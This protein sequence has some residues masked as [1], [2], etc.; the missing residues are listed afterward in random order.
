[1]QIGMQI[2]T[3]YEPRG[4]SEFDKRFDV[5]YFVFSKA[6][7][8][9]RFYARYQVARAFRG[10]QL[11]GYTDTTEIGYA[12]LIKL[13]LHWSAFEQLKKAIRVQ[14]TRELI[15]LYNFEEEISELRK[16]PH[17]DQFFIFVVKHLDEKSDYSKNKIKKHIE[18]ED[19]NILVLSQSIRH[20]FLHGHLTPNARGVSPN[21]VEKLC[22]TLSN[23]L[24]NVMDN[25]FEKK[26]AQLIE[27][28]PS[29]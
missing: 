5:A 26:V 25:E 7:A 4:W 20:V 19:A 8:V 16:D 10:I 17:H 18:N 12:G 11:E 13:F 9:N 21:F 24:V 6:A 14:D 15:N 3:R 23:C 29:K 27:M 2:P 1:M 22:D 28:F